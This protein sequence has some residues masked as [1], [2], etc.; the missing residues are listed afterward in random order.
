RTFH[1]P[2]F[3]TPSGK[4]ILHVHS[5][6]ELR[7]LGPRELRLMTVRSE[8]Q[9][10]TVVYED[11]DLYRGQDRRDIILLHPDDIARLGLKD[12][13]RVTIAS[14]TGRMPNI[15]VRSFEQIRAGNAMMYYPEA[16]V[17]V[18]RTA[19]NQSKTPAFKCI[20]IT[21]EA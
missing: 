3:P 8:G 7:A 17:L 10:N 13:Q 5:I 18:P 12:E 15:L 11:Y 14:E 20:F 21:I 4:A 16:N 2:Q 9:F 6:P 19:D 1:E